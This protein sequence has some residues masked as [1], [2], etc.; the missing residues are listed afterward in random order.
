[1]SFP[2]FLINYRWQSFSCYYSPWWLSIT[3]LINTEEWEPSSLW[4]S[5]TADAGKETGA[6]CSGRQRS[7]NTHAGREHAAVLIKDLSDSPLFNPVTPEFP[8]QRV[9]WPTTSRFHHSWV[10]VRLTPLIKNKRESSD[11]FLAAG[12]VSV[13]VA[14][15]YAA[16][17]TRSHLAADHLRLCLMDEFFPD[18]CQIYANRV[19]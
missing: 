19:I 17:Q 18:R 12:F 3:A 13:S 10:I 1:M 2:G 11:S 8:W 14:C 15:D 7:V 5:I 16:A 6:P 9:G 4:F